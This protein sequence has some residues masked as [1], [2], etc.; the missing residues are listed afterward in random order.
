MKRTIIYLVACAVF[1]APG[2]WPVPCSADPASTS[3][4]W[5]AHDMTYQWAKL[6]PIVATQLGITGYDGMLDTPSAAQDQRDL[7]LIRTW[8]GRLAAIST[9]G[10]PLNVR[11]DSTLLRAQL[12]GMER[13]YTV[14]RTDTKD[15]AA[16]GNAIT[17][18]IF[19]QFQRLPVAGRE[20]ATTADVHAAWLDIIARLA[21]AP[22]YV[23]AG[24]SLVTHPGHL[25]GVVGSDELAG[26]PDFFNGSLTDAAKAQL[27]ASDFEK[28]TAARDAALTAIADE[29][30][31]IDAHEAAWPENFAIGRH[32]YEAMLRDEQL[33]PFNA[34]TIESMG[35]DELAHGWA[36]TYWLYNV[37]AVR[38]VSIGPSTG[39]GLAPGGAALIPYY[40][41]QIAYLQRFVTQHRVV[42]VPQWL[43]TIDVVE[44]PKFL[45]P[46]SPGASMQSPRLLSPETKGFYFITPPV[47]LTE[48]AARLDANED[49]DRDRILSTAAHE[50]MPG[51][52]LQMSIARRNPDFVRKI[53]G[54]GSFAEGWAYYGE[55]MFV[56]LGLYG[57][58]LDG[59]LD[60][61]QWER[62][63]GARAIVD[64][65]LASGEMTEPQAAAYFAEQTGFTPAA[66]KEAVDGIALFPGYVISYTVGRQQIQLLEHQYFAAMGSRGSLEDFHDRL[67]CYGTTP[68]SIV[69]PELLAD[70]S[71]PLSQVRAAA[72]AR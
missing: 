3:L 11:D 48:A 15:Y 61:A 22:A 17:D 26:A 1:A 37:A 71:K 30:A 14:Y 49:F 62:V 70:L 18:I 53:Q 19:T 50:V 32:A 65:K 28:F 21:K 25:Q 29:K 34:T 38:G 52:F 12:T 51:H 66:A 35:M 43:G 69:A 24:E 6:H 2:A 42:N 60:V 56:W 57:D 10:E 5:L 41:K 68:L 72:G 59:R 7:A 13:Q 54:S 67:L 55:E 36:V 46:V 45:Q 20:N 4:Q 47:S 8:Q 39:G 27:P 23:A 9:S 31:Y 63:R 33:V 16:P 58:D 64:A 40:R 44:T